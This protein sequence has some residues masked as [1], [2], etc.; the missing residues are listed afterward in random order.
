MARIA[1]LML[2]FTLCLTGLPGLA[3]ASP[4]IWELAGTFTST[5]GYVLDAGIT[6]GMPLSFR[7]TLPSEVGPDGCSRDDQAFW[8]LP[9][10]VPFSPPYGV[11][12]TA[13]GQSYSGR[14]A[15]LEVNDPFLTCAGSGGSTTSASYILRIS[16][17]SLGPVGGGALLIWS[18]PN[19]PDLYPFPIPQSAFLQIVPCQFFCRDVAEATLTTVTPVPEPGT[20]LLLGPS[21]IGAIWRARRRRLRS[22]S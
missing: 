21:A 7:V 3:S 12:L 11:V 20:L 9:S 2:V 14:A 18:S 22:M 16:D 13:G 6:A 5:S 1:R 17:F 4:I 10:A 15:G 19:S 8:P